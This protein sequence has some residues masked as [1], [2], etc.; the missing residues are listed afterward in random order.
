M[1]VERRCIFG[2]LLSKQSG[3]QSSRTLDR[4]KQGDQKWQLAFRPYVQKGILQKR[5]AFK[6]GGFCR[7]VQVRKGPGS[8]LILVIIEYR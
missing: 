1:G 6:L 7:R 2:R 4:L 5:T 8:S 3:E